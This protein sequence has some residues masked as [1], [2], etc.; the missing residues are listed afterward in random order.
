MFRTEARADIVHVPYK[1]P[2]PAMQDVI[3]GHVKIMFAP[4]AL[5]ANHVRAGRLRA[6]AVA[7]ARRSPLLPGV[8]TI[9]ELGHPGFDATTWYG[10]VAPVGTPKEI[11]DVLHHST[12]AVLDDPAAR[13]TMRALG[14]DVVASSPREFEAYIKAQV[15]R[16]HQVDRHAHPLTAGGRHRRNAADRAIRPADLPV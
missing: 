5:V 12:A 3:G 1:K 15:G 2:A 11:V 14:I 13:K 9:E 6:L 4:A 10:L 8:A 7:T 16:D